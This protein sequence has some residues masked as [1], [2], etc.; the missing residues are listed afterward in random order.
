[1]DKI[2]YEEIVTTFNRPVLVLAGPGAGKTYLLGDRTKR[3]LDVGMNKECI[4][5]LTFGKDASQNMRNKLLDPH[6]G[7]GIPYDKL[8][9]VATLHSISFEIVNKKPHSVNLNKTDL[10]VQ[11]NED[12]KRLLF[13]DAALILGLSENEANNALL[14][15]QNGDFEIDI[16]NGLQII[17]T[18]YWEIMSKC[19]YIDFDD[20]VNFA[21]QI[22][23][24]DESILNEYQARCKYLLVDEYQDINASQF[25]LIKL[26]SNGSGHGLFAV[27]DDAQSI[28]GFRGSNPKY[29]LNFGQD[30]DNSL[31]PPLAHSRRCHRQII[32][33]AARIL[34]IYYPEWTGLYELHYH[35]PDGREP[36]LFQV[37]S[38][39]MEAELTARI[40]RKAVS[41]KQSVLILAPKKEFFPLISLALRRYS[42]PHR[43]PVNL[44]PEKVN[45]RLSRVSN[46]LKWLE[47]SEDSFLTRLVIESF[48]DHGVTKIPGADKSHRCS[49]QTIEKRIKIEFEVAKLWDIVSKK[50]SLFTIL[51]NQPQLSNELEAIRDRLSKLL[52]LYKETGRKFHGEFAKQLSLAV[53]NWDEPQKFANDLSLIINQV[54]SGDVMGFGSVQLMTMRKAKGLEAD[55]VIIVGLEDDI[56]PNPNSDIKEEARLFYVSM[57]RAKEKLY[58][59]HSFKRLRSISYGPEITEKKRSRFLD[60][61][62]RKSKYLKGDGRTS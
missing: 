7:F 22:L 36:D 21:C 58:L 44:L 31:T 18:K 3:L 13:R 55:V 5:L 62:G 9:H 41:E 24:S 4:T 38:D 1:V 33:D 48:M 2:E 16:N 8:P 11:T 49:Q 29:I 46:I 37:P 56:M 53:G 25:N 57:T 32:E 47:N 35:M 54:E 12:V 23:Q 30:F 6:A 40:A 59:L 50:N 27:G 28:Y 14:Y 26:L 20:Q 15:K 17:C 43:C 19:N 51:L 52:S 45:D 42:V 60:S 10:Q 34:K 39:K 61:I